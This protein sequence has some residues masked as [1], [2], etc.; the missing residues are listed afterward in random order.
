M[1]DQTVARILY[2]AL[3]YGSREQRIR[4]LAA[5][6]DIGIRAL[7]YRLEAAGLITDAGISEQ[8]VQNMHRIERTP[9]RK[10]R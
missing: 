9:P 8:V 4:A 7:M 1:D 6:N 2:I 10:R 5:A 3:G